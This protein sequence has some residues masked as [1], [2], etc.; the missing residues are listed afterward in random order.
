M[1]Q[2]G[3]MVRRPDANVV[4]LLIVDFVM[5]GDTFMSVLFLYYSHNPL[6]VRRPVL[7]FSL[8]VDVGRVQ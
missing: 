6:S 5:Q 3:A 8:L 7:L 4:R 1:M 2:L